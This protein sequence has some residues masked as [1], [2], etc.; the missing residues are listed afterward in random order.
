MRKL[1]LLLYFFTLSWTSAFSLTWTISFPIIISCI[2][3]ILVLINTISGRMNSVLFKAEFMLV[4]FVVAVLVSYLINLPSFLSSKPTNHLIAYLFTVIIL[5]FCI[6]LY[7]N[8]LNSKISDFLGKV[9]KWLSFGVF[10]SATFG[11]FEFLSKNLFDFSID[12]YIPRSFVEE[13]TPT[14][15]GKFIRLRSFVEESGHYAL[16]IEICLPLMVYYFFYHPTGKAT[17][18]IV[19]YIYVIITII[20]F[21][22]TFSS[23]GIAIAGIMLVVL[24]LTNIQ[25]RITPQFL[26]TFVFI[27][28]VIIGLVYWTN[29]YLIDELNININEALNILTIEKATD[30]GS[31][32]DRTEKIQTAIEVIKNSNILNLLIGYGPAAYDSL[33][34]DIVIGLYV[35]LFLETGI[36]GLTFF[37]CF[38]IY[39]YLKLFS[40]QNKPFR[41]SLTISI[42]SA[43]IHYLFIGNYYYP[44]LWLACGIV[45]LYPLAEYNHATE[46]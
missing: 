27:L 7:F 13:Y 22:F 14:F 45:Y 9:L 21:I 44:W 25:S 39:I 26:T 41:T 23:A 28:V 34:I 43:L 18:R 42:S 38:F 12:E 8:Y 16:F 15:L 32:M 24:G 6:R 10:V 40:I 19:A 4:A 17:R 1:L 36:F 46:N 5:Y 30:S 31:Q 35:V 33:R 29:N 11:L 37:V 3:G 2:F 20:A